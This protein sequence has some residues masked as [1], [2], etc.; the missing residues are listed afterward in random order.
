MDKNKI[1]EKLLKNWIVKVICLVLA[2]F[3]YL[4]YQS[5]LTE[6][7]IFIIP[8]EIIEDGSVMH[9]G[10]IE[11]KVSVEVRTDKDEMIKIQNSDLR[12]SINLDSLY[13]NGSHEIPVNID[14][15]EKIM[16][17]NTLEIRIKPE[18]VNVHVEK[19]SSR[20][21]PVQASVVGNVANG[22]EISAIDCNP[23]VV[24]VFGPESVVNNIS[25]IATDKVFVNNAERNFTVE[26]NYQ[27]F[28]KYINIIDTEPCKVTVTLGQLSMEK[29]FEGLAVKPVNLSDDFDLIM[30]YPALSVKVTGFVSVLDKYEI[31]KSALQVDLKGL[32]EEGTYEL[33]VKINLPA[34]INLV[35]KSMDNISVVLTKKN[36]ETL[37]NILTENPESSGAKIE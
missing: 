17:F 21:I 15:S 28:N 14:F 35:S 19:K 20:Y 2:L 34:G 30:E 6:K 4:F 24:Q 13:E 25:Y 8:L 32:S 1:T 31:S 22:Y 12:A 16:S 29:T 36:I 23:S 33:P 18:K 3:L 7:K 5:T 37:E 26:A 10:N 11:K 27:N 9:V